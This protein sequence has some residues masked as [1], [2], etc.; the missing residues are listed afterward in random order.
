MARHPLQ[1]RRHRSRPPRP[2]ASQIHRQLYGTTR[3]RE[4]RAAVPTAPTPASYQAPATS[5]ASPESRR[6]CSG[7]TTAETV[8]SAACDERRWCPAPAS[9]PTRRIQRRRASSPSP[10]AS[11]GLQRRRTTTSTYSTIRWRS[12]SA[13]CRGTRRSPISHPCRRRTE[14]C[15]DCSVACAADAGGAG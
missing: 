3:R 15:V 2:Q 4:T 6:W 7:S 10:S 12:S 13:F 14:A 11:D 9:S 1:S 8:D 5:P